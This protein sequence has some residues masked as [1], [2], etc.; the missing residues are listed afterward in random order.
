MQ[1]PQVNTLVCLMNIERSC[2]RC[3][4]TMHGRAFLAHGGCSD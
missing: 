2:L 4:A 1:R 3:G